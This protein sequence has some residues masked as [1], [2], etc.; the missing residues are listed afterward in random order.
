[1]VC[2]LIRFGSL[3]GTFA[4]QIQQLHTKWNTIWYA[5]FLALTLH[6]GSHMTTPYCWDID[7]ID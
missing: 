7:V 3:C 6:G 2:A 1:V 5:S 4:Q